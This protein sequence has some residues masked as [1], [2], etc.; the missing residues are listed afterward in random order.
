MN[1]F[2]VFWILLL[3]PFLLLA[4][5]RNETVI[6][7]SGG[8]RGRVEG[9]SGCPSGSSGGFGRRATVMKEIFSDY[10]PVSVDCGGILDLDPEGGMNASRCTFFGLAQ[11][12]LK[13]LGVMPRDMFYGIEFLKSTA[14]SSGVTLVSGNIIEAATEEPLFEIWATVSSGNKRFAV[15]S[16]ANY[17]Q[18][19]KYVAPIGWTI[20]HQDSVIQHLAA[21]IPQNIDYTILLTNMGEG[22]IR[23]FIG[24]YPYFNLVLTSSRQFY[25]ESHFLLE[26][27]LVAHPKPDGQSIDW[28]VFHNDTPPRFKTRLLPQSIKVNPKTNEWLHDCLGRKQ[29]DQK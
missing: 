29:L 8:F 4:E 25:T 24:K 1:R 11:M 23:E 19:R 20:T 15:A 14:D 6:L 22:S 3:C 16:L 13:V 12:G 9:C 17:Q 5:N 18:G 21:T 28:V 26:E 2:P 27:I 10:M 7:V